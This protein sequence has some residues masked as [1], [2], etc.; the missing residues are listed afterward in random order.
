MKTDVVIMAAGEG[1]RM[2]SSLPKVLHEAAGRSLVA[3]VAK[4]AEAVAAK[5]IIIYG[6]GG[7]LI[8]NTL[9]DAY[10][11]A[12]Q[13]ERL[14]SGHA[15][16]AAKE[17]FKDS[18]YT[19]VI[20]G[21]M[22]LIKAETVATLVA[23]TQ[24][25]GCDLMLLTASPEQTPAYGRVVRDDKGNICRIVE[26]KDATPAQKAIKELNISVY[27]FKTEA[28]LFALNKITPD[29]AQKE[30]Y[31]TDTV[32]I[33]YDAGKDVRSSG[34]DD[35]QECLG[36]N[37]RVQLAEVTTVLRHRIAQEVMLGGATLIDPANTY[38]DAD[39]VVGQDT[40]IYPGVVL[41]KGSIIGANCTL[42]QGS[43]IENSELANG[44]TVENSVMQNAKVGENTTV[45]PYAYLRP[46]TV[47]GRNCRVGDFVEI[48][49][50]TIGDGTKVSHLTYVGDAELGED[51]NIA[52]GVVFSNYDGKKKHITK[53]EDRAFIGCNT[54][55][56]PPVHVGEGAYIAAGSTI[57]KDV[58]ADAL[59]I[60]RAR[61][62]IKE[63]R[64]AGRYKEKKQKTEG[65]ESK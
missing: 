17:Q 19:V 22:P 39:V 23:E 26:D 34:I 60:A 59:V 24:N 47:V 13:K 5:P 33:L 12:L 55:L 35:M 20:A 52:C 58:P 46:G 21:D 4:A 54:N 36:V 14:G 3:W 50:A 15:V 53:V 49:N 8:P 9:G 28:L 29:N 44:V 31:L 43:R 41:Q 27:C 11:Y 6:S 65:K 63:G 1:T 45:G 18:D 2:K 62:V 48:K 37:N 30:Y 16:M 32:H 57:T 64:G 61:E 40:V 42:Y 10:T 7:D 25:S 56:I 38:I 51:I